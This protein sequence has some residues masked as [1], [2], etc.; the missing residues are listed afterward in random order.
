MCSVLYRGVRVFVDRFLNCQDLSNALIIEL[1]FQLQVSNSAQS[2]LECLLQRVLESAISNFD[3]Q[4]YT[5][6]IKARYSQNFN[7]TMGKEQGEKESI[8]VGPIKA[9]YARA[10]ARDQ[11]LSSRLL[12]RIQ[13]QASKLTDKQLKDF[14]V[15]LM[16]EM[17]TVV[18]ISSSDAQECYQSLIALY[19]TQIVGKEPKFPN[20]W[21]RPEEVTP[22]CYMSCGDCLQTK[23][24][25]K[26]PEADSYRLLSQDNWH[27]ESEHH[28]FKY[29]EIDKRDDKSVVITKTFK[30]WEKQHS[31]WESR[32]SDALEVLRKFPQGKLK[33][34]LA[35]RYDEIMNLRM[36]RVDDSPTR[37]ESTSEVLPE[38]RSAVPQKRS[39]SDS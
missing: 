4:R 2:F 36:V 25:L 23:E 12:K 14:L 27:V 1:F 21:S 3:L 26:D 13:T 38:T 39:R 19:I 30:W 37:S 29:F 10:H 22:I 16:E 18:D 5:T 15:P 8:R 7:R 9:I 34:C 32:A 35:Y 6:Y 20:N 31:R 11:G 24:F 28:N 33:E 17:I